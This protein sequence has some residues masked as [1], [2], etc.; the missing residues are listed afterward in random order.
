MQAERGATLVPA[1]NASVWEQGVSTRLVLYRNLAFSDA[2]VQGLR[3]VGVQ[4]LNGKA[5]EAPVDT[6]C[7]FDIEEVDPQTPPISKFAQFINM[8]YIRVAWSQSNTTSA[9]RY[10]TTCL[11]RA[12]SES[13]VTPPWR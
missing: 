3:L 11:H 8:S 13:W 9:N 2:K 1:I 6:I 12:R 5:S 4:K 10:Q 7:A